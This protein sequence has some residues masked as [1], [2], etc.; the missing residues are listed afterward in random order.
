MGFEGKCIDLHVHLGRSR[1]GAS[2]SLV[3]IR[4]TMKRYGVSRA[5]LFPI[6]E[7]DAGPTYEKTNQKVLNAAASDSRLVPFARL[8]PA[9]GRAVFQELDR[10]VKAGVRGIKLHPRSEKFS[11][12]GAETLIDEIERRRLPVILH[13]SHEKN[14][15]PLSWEK[16][17][18]RHPRIPFVL[19]HGG[20]DAFEEAI[21]V[22]HRNRNVWLETSTLSYWRTSVI[23]KKLGASR[24]VFGSDLP[25]SHPLLERLKLDIL[26]EPGG[27]RRVYSENPLRILGE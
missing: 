8:N 9:S 10:C 24:V 19:A 18:R 14:C 7:A 21:S 12:A 16:I 11:P 2:L 1:D 23:L 20:K 22:A 13:T 27:R 3:E 6:D 26:L 5:A 4:R 15:R 17:F 25:Y